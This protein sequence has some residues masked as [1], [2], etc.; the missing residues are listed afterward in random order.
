[1]KI[2]APAKINLVLDVIGKRSDGYHN[3]KMIMQSLELGDVV[4]VEAQAADKTEIIINS[5]SAVVPCNESNIAYKAAM[6]ILDDANMRCNV[7]IDIQKNIPIC[8]GL[9]GGST[10]GAAVLIALNSILGLD[11]SKE[12]LM[13]LG[14]KIG[15]DV[16]FCIM[17]GTALAQGTG[18]ELSAIASYGKHTV[19]LVKPD[20]DVSTPWVYKNLKLNTVTH[21]DVDSFIDCIKHGEYAQS[22]KHMG[23]VLET[24]TVEEYPIIDKIKKRMMDCGARVSM[25]SGSGPTV[26]GIFDSI[27]AAN[28]AAEIFKKEFKQVIVTKTV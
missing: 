10:N 25:M 9:A 14:A 27:E 21:P 22:Y 3:V 16:P 4:T 28:Q 15:A 13:N 17:Q 7:H 26:F 8:A 19:L 6:A 12:K 5:N 18:T 23:N 11:Y 24:V 2:H 20:I 1:M